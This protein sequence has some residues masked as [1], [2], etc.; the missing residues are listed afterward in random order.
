MRL[1][2]SWVV[3]CTTGFKPRGGEGGGVLM[4]KMDDVRRGFSPQMLKLADICPIFKKKDK[5]RCENYRPI[6]LLSNLSKLFERAMHTRIYEFLEQCNIFSDLQFGFRKKHS[7]NHALLSIFENIK[8]KL[9]FLL[10][11]FH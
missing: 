2:C 10:R 1:A 3:Q 7:T 9:D 5:N 4:M 8:G 6:S 11:C